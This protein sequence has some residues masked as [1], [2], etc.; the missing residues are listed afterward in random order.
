M[1]YLRHLI[2]FFLVFILH[3]LIT[4]NALGCSCIESKIPPCAAYWRAHA[5]FVGSVM[6][7]VPPPKQLTNSLPEATLR[8]SV[9]EAFRGAAVG[10]TIE[11]YALSGTSCDS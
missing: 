3:P 7:I 5:V 10:T 2:P 8:L 9:E 6:S 4:S 11:V 1:P